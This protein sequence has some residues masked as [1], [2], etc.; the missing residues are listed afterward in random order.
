MALAPAVLVACVLVFVQEAPIVPPADAPP[1][2]PAQEAAPDEQGTEA[3]TP[4][5]LR[6]QQEAPAT[7][8]E[9]GAQIAAPPAEGSAASNVVIVI[10]TIVI[11]LAAIVQVVVANAQWRVAQQ[12]AKTARDALLLLNRPWLDVEGWELSSGGARNTRVRLR[13]SFH[14]V[15]RSHTPVLLQTASVTLGEATRHDIEIYNQLN[16]GN[17]QT[18]HI[19]PQLLPDDQRDT[20]FDGEC[21]LEIRGELHFKNRFLEQRAMPFAV[22]ARFNNGT[23]GGRFSSPYL[24]HLNVTQDWEA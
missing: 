9:A 1:D 11:A 16:P 17:T 2:L 15:N 12:G 22:K 4:V 5:G 19:P 21:A 13:F 23:P 24:T 20:Y 7:P 8:P 6:E 18:V 14:V 3:V 10:A